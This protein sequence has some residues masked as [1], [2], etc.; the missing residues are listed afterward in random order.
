MARSFPEMPMIPWKLVEVA[1][2]RG[3]E[4]ELLLYRRGSDFS[5]RIGTR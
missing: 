5:M 1:R 3:D 4:G 2:L